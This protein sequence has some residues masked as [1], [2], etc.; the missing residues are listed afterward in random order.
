MLMMTGCASHSAG[1]GDSARAG[2]SSLA[3]AGLSDAD[4]VFDRAN[5]D[6]GNGLEA[7]EIERMGL[8]PYWNMLDQDGDGRISRQE[9]R[10]RFDDTAIQRQLQRTAQASGASAPATVSPAWRLPPEAPARQW[11]PE[12]T[13]P[14]ATLTTPSAAAWGVTPPADPDAPSSSDSSDEKT[15]SP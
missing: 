2:A 5:A 11:R 9:F 14:P 8:G 15:V 7:L 3:G 6:P 1:E 4:S 10:Q 12:A 13:T